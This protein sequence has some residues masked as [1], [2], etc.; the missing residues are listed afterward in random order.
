MTYFP[1]ADRKVRLGRPTSYPWDEWTD[2]QER[3]FREGEDFTSMAES[4]VLL[5]RRTAR[6]RGLSVVVSTITVHS[7][8]APQQIDVNGQPTWMQPG[9]TYVL[10]K[11]GHGTLE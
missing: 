4:F 7:R 8:S 1:N 2:G 10:V 9:G 3:L 6:V 5:V 11:F